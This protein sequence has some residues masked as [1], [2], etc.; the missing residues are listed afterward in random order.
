MSDVTACL[1]QKSASEII[2][3]SLNFVGGEQDSG[4]NGPNVDGVILPDLPRL[5]MASGKHNKMPVIM[6][7]TE[8][9]FSTML[10][11][12]GTTYVANNAEYLAMV[13]AYFGKTYGPLFA[14]WYPS[15][16]FSSANAAWI[17]MLSD[18]SF[19]CPTREALIAL[20]KNQT[21][22]VWRG[23]FTHI[24]AGGPLVPYG[25]GHGFDMLFTFGTLN[26][27]GNQSTAA[28]EALAQAMRR[29]W[30]R[31]AKDGDPNGASDINW[32]AY[33][34]KLDDYLV[35]ETPTSVGYGMHKAHC[36]LWQPLL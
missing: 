12:Y 4:Y 30:T 35:F 14:A 5:V 32:P 3:T 19:T 10:G 18:Y 25:A 21:E 1:R 20:A 15:K 33:D 6:T 29:Y 36:D 23:V 31:F 11:L 9:E 24:M 2:T 27:A 22:P 17:A 7:T 16:N 34:P 28:E 8:H 26:Y 13:N